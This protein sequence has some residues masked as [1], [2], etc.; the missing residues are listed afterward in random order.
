MRP[1]LMG[2]F[3]RWRATGWVVKWVVPTRVQQW[4]EPVDF[5]EVE[6]RSRIAVFSLPQLLPPIF[7]GFSVCREGCVRFDIPSRG[8]GW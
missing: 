2:V 5:V 8:K 7:R 1:V 4:N 3:I 6:T